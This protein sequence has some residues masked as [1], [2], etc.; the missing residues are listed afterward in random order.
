MNKSNDTHSYVITGEQLLN[1]NTDKMPYLLEP[2]F[3]KV[4][5]ASIVGSSDTG[6]SSFLREFATAVSTGQEY[7]LQWRINATHNSAIYVSTEDDDSSIAYLLNKQNSE[8]KYESKKLASLRYIFET[9][10][11][12]DKLDSVL[13][14]NPADLVIIDAFA[15]LY[16]GSLNDS[17]QVRSFLQNYSQLANNHKC[18]VIFLHHTGKRTETQSPNKN[19]VLGSQGFEAKMRIVAELRA[20]KNCPQKKHF[21]IVKGNYLPAEY[22]NSSYV[23]EFSNNMTFKDT[24]ER[25][26]FDNLGVS[27]EKLA[28]YQIAKEL[29]QQGKTL[30]EI[31]PQIGLKNK[32]N[33]SRLLKECESLDDSLFTEIKK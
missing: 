5:L 26:S 2:I 13:T 21:C 18:L 24:G 6:K 15:D 12:V 1:R 30:E 14:K 10:N 16:Y 11:L 27:D 25:I 9:D 31:A 17:T 4:G 3:Q 33:V 22:K 32:G 23:L 28:K 19:N 20:D 29:K 8:R 7:F